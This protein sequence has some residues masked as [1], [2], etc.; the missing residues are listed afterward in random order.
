MDK[1][2]DIGDFGGGSLAPEAVAAPGPHLGLT[3]PGSTKLP[4]AAKSALRR[5]KSRA[6]ASILPLTGALA[7]G[8]LRP[9]AVGEEPLLVGEVGVIK[10]LEAAL[11]HP[12]A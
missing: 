10:G 3:H 8:A 6:G 7:R 2:D 12:A 4:R 1:G 9:H 5:R 11:L